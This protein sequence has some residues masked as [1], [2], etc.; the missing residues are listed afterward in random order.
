MKKQI[1]ILISGRGSNLQSIISNSLNEDFPGEVSLVISDNR[2]ALGLNI[3]I[4]NNIPYCIVERKQFDSNIT[5]E[6]CI[7]EHINKYNASLICLAGFMKILSNEFIALFKDKIINI[8]PSLLPK[9]KG[10]NTHQRVLESKDEISGCT[11]HFVNGEVD[12]GN[13]IL[14]ESVPINNNE[15]IET[16]SK[17]ILEVEH[18]IYPAAIKQLLS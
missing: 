18:R 13:I 10:L 2:D 4:K 7:S 5:F 17:K 11:V 8:H 14:Q 9:Y 6:R 1:V 15:T 12:S 3:A 16:L